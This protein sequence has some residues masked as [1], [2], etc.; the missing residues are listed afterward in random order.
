LIAGASVAQALDQVK[1][2][3]KWP[4]DILVNEKKD[5]WIDCRNRR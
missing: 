1:A 3:V 2:T 4:N 5:F